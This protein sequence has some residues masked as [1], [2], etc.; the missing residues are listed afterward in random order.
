MSYHWKYHKKADYKK[1]KKSDV[2]ILNQTVS[3][4]IGERNNVQPNSSKKR[5]EK[6]N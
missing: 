2:L 6:N 1:Y 5:R 4:K 3:S